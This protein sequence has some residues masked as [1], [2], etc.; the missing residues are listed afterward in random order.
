MLGKRKHWKNVPTA[1]NGLHTCSFMEQ[2]ILGKIG[3][4]ALAVFVIVSF[5][6]FQGDVI[7]ESGTK[8]I[9]C[10]DIYTIISVRMKF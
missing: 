1:V 3:A 6:Q 8:D 10:T 4:I 5:N 7:T 9:V 2:M